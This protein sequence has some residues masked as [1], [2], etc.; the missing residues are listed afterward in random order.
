MVNQYA[1]CGW[2]MVQMDFDGGMTPWDGVGG[3]VPNSL[4]VLR[5][6]KRADSGPYMALCKLCGPSVFSV[7]IEEWCKV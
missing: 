6:V 3:V 2:A 7:T 1:A 5:I 4:E